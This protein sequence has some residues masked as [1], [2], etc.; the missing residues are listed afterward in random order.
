MIGLEMAK[1]RECDVVVVGDVDRLEGDE[2]K[3]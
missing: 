2:G 3:E 1:E